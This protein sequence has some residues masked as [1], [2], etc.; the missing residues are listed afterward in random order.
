MSPEQVVRA[1]FAAYSDGAPDRFDEVVAPDYTDYGHTPPGRG[2][3]GAKD[4]YEH[5][6]QMV[7]GAISY[8][9]DALVSRDDTVAVAWTGHLP[10]GKVYRGL[11][12]YLVTNG[13]IAETRHA[14]IGALPS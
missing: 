8:D 13:K 14:T 5:A 2:P 11:S 12:L 9:I 1:F 10:D 7:G 3:Q 6:I 4:D